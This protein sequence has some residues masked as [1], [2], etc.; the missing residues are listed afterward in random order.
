MP[1]S[2]KF[3][4]ILFFMAVVVGMLPL[5]ADAA[6]KA[7]KVQKA[8]IHMKTL[9]TISVGNGTQL[10]VY[11]NVI[12]S[13]SPSSK[14]K[15]VYIRAMDKG[16]TVKKSN[17]YKDYGVF[18]S[19]KLEF[20]KPGVHKVRVSVRLKGVKQ[21]TRKIIKFRVGKNLSDEVKGL[22][23][24]TTYINN[25]FDYRKGITY[26]KKAVKSYQVDSGNVHL[27]K[28]GTY[29]AKYTIKGVS[30]ETVKVTRVIKVANDP[31]VVSE[32]LYNRIMSNVDG[33][34]DRAFVAGSK[35]IS[36]WHGVVANSTVDTVTLDV[37]DI[38][39]APSPTSAN[40]F[41]SK[42]ITYTV[43]FKDGVKG[44]VS[45]TIYFVDYDTG[46]EMANRGMSVYMDDMEEVPFDISL[47]LY[48]DIKPGTCIYKQG[49]KDV[50]VCSKCIKCFGTV[51]EFNEHCQGSL[52][53]GSVITKKVPSMSVVC[54]W[55]LKEK[56]NIYARRGRVAN[57]K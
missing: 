10:E 29:K 21:L 56:N 25:K 2:R 13:I 51:L 34:V 45:N 6:P 57:E 46:K 40:P 49:S 31:K 38:K 20:T 16:V 43:V 4:V 18:A 44:S 54:P 37:D 48:Y 22:T 23:P 3:Y 55:L 32:E 53:G 1:K 15:N 50:Y 41:F 35:N 9:G 52:C 27:D 33:L 42:K 24:A 39:E 36:Y 11:K 19:K 30:G 17:V 28:L 26:N 7:Q 8:K 12:K 47:L 5:K 14:V